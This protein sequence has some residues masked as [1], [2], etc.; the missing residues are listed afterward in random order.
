MR[1]FFGCLLLRAGMALL[2]KDVRQ[3]VRRVLMYHVP[4]GLTEAEKADVERRVG[5]VRLAA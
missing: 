2:P 3:M 1:V 5:S 4:G